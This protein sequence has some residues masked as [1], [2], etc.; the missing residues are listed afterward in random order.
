MGTGKGAAPAP[1]QELSLAVMGR[2]EEA[3]RET[4]GQEEWKGDGCSRLQ[5]RRGSL[6]LRGAEGRRL[7]R[8]TTRE[9]PWKGA[10][11]SP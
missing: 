7:I 8:V 4:L 11:G 9:A 10:G 3:W 1:P 6:E 5:G 2:T